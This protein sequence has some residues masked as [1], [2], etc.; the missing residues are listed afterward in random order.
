MV[1]FVA[2]RV[3][4]IELIRYFYKFVLQQQIQQCE[5][6]SVWLFSTVLKINHFSQ[7]LALT[8]YVLDIVLP[9]VAQRLDAM[10][11]TTPQSLD[12]MTLST[13]TSIISDCYLYLDNQM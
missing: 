6:W 5:T 10:T 2:S 11:H 12:G 13:P 1:L 7:V 8:C 4:L 3:L 9:A